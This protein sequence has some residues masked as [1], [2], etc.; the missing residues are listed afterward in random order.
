MGIREMH[1]KELHKFY[2]SRTIIKIIKSWGMSLVG[3]VAAEC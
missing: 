3:Y 2:S 1:Y